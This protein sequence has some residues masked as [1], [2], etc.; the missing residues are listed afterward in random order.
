MTTATDH[1]TLQGHS[2]AHLEYGCQDYAHSF[3][4]GRLQAAIV[5]DGCSS[6]PNSDVGARLTTVAMARTLT[7]TLPWLLTGEELGLQPKF[8]EAFY[9]ELH[10]VQ[11]TIGREVGFSPLLMDCT[12]LACACYEER[13]FIFMFG[14]GLVGVHY[15]DDSFELYTRD[16][17]A[18]LGGLRCSAPNYPAYQL[19]S[20]EARRGSYNDAAVQEVLTVDRLS[21]NGWERTLTQTTEKPTNSFYLPLELARVRGVFLSSDGLSSFDSAKVD[22]QNEIALDLLRVPKVVDKNLLRRRMLF[23]SSRN[24][25]KKGWKHQDDLGIAGIFKLP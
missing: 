18:I 22:W 5:S 1:F 23:Y 2:L 20:N 13:L 15:E 14:D 4:A 17:T 11:V 8:E 21:N 7:Y 6:A 24:W 10:K 25:P 19:P 12:A 16:Y 3:T 9:Q